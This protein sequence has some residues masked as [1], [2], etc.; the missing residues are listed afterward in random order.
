MKYTGV[1]V[2]QCVFHVASRSKAQIRSCQSS[3]E[4]ISSN[5]TLPF[6]RAHSATFARTELFLLLLEIMGLLTCQALLKGVRAAE[7]LR[8]R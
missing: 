7:A 8:Q 3:S 2:P 1:C 4:P 5:D 6:L